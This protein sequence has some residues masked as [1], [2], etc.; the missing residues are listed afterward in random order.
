MGG[1][2][3]RF[4]LDKGDSQLLFADWFFVFDD[5]GAGVRSIY[6]HGRP[7]AYVQKLQDISANEWR[8]SVVSSFD[9][10]RLKNI[11]FTKAD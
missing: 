7:A 11:H 6:V 9:E 4:T 10:P 3:L 8:A 5:E 1:Y 2:N